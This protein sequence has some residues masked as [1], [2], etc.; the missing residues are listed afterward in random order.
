MNWFDLFLLVVF[1]L[2]V[3]NGFSRGLVKVLFDIFGFFVVII[4]ALWGSRHFGRELAEYINP[5]DIIPHHDL[6]LRLDIEVALEKAPELVGGIIAF[7]VLFLL[8]SIVFRL[9]AGSFRWINRIPV[10]GLF[11][12]IGGGGLGALVGAV[13]IYI[14]IAGVALIPLQFFMRALENSEMVL[15]AEHYLAPA[16]EELKTRAI[17]YFLNFNG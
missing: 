16:A 1:A 4:L 11:N 3:L 17:K 8:L 9:F 14:I 2:H 15:L 7:L 5:E 13:F 6:F 10:I 12:R